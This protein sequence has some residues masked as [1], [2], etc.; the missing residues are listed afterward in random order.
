MSVYVDRAKNPY[1]RM[2]MSHMLADTL[3]ELHAMADCIGI[4]RKWFQPKSTPHYDICQEK[5]RLAL[6]AGAIECDR[7]TVV[8]LIRHYRSKAE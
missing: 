2:L 4:Q 7:R 3:E 6:A 1:R 5:K 8:R